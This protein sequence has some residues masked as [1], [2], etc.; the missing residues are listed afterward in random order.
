MGAVLSKVEEAKNTEQPEVIKKDLK[1]PDE[2]INGNMHIIRREGQKFYMH[3]S[4]LPEDIDR[5][6]PIALWVQTNNAGEVR[7]ANAAV[8]VLVE[9]LEKFEIDE[10]IIERQKEKTKGNPGYMRVGKMISMALRHNIPLANIVAALDRVPEVYVT[11][12][13]FA[14]KKFLAQQIQDGTDI[15]GVTCSVCGSDN[16][17]FESGCTMCKACGASECG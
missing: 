11:D 5:I 14:I 2:F 1:L 3:F 17:V 10:N 8:K 7:E 12:L 16:V 13:I 15:Q 9:L 6:F 4:Y